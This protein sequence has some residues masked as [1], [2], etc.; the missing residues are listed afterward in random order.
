MFG[1]QYR[2]N[3]KKIMS[4]QQKSQCILVFK[5]NNS[6][7]SGGQARLTTIDLLN[8]FL[9]RQPGVVAHACNPVTRRLG[10]FNGFGAGFLGGGCSM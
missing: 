6:Y 1:V 9:F 5:I 2:F 4:F 7:T 3:F 10:S 8:L